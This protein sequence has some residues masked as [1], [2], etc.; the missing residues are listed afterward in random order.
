MNINKKLF[1]VVV[2]VLWVIFMKSASSFAVW[3]PRFEEPWKIE[4]SFRA[5]FDKT[6]NA[7]LKAVELSNGKVVT[8]DKSSGVIVYFLSSSFFPEHNIFGRV[9]YYR[10]YV[11]VYLKKHP[12]INDTTIVYAV[13]KIQDLTDIEGITSL[14]IREEAPLEKVFKKEL[15]VQKAFFE[16]IEKNI[17]GE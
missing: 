13:P 16:K 15:E 6:W 8:Q 1:C 3:M 9:Y 7:A 2:I 14:K 11:N 17:K 4:K 12:T 10:I 5:S